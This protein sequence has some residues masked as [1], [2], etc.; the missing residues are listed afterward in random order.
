MRTTM[1][2]CGLP[3]AQGISSERA[4]IV[5]P[6]H[7]AFLVQRNV[8]NICHGVH[9]IVL[10]QRVQDEV[11]RD[12][13]PD[14]STQILA[15]HLQPIHPA[16]EGNRTLLR[17]PAGVISTSGHPH[18]CSRIQVTCQSIHHDRREILALQDH[19]S[20]KRSLL[21]VNPLW[22]GGSRQ[23]IGFF[24]RPKCHSRSWPGRA[25]TLGP[26]QSLASRPLPQTGCIDTFSHLGSQHRLPQS[27]GSHPE[28][29]QQQPPACPTLLTELP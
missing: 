16:A 18:T 29:R 27:L 2:I 21:Q 24:V 6:N 9:V 28:I 26:L 23:S 14:L 5:Y 8:A 25:I 13:S 3:I 1:V 7:L 10:Q 19:S 15:Q 12:L 20:H 22:L 11:L 4:A 17:V